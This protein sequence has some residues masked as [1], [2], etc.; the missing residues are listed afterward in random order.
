VQAKA[1]ANLPVLDSKGRTDHEMPKLH[2]SQDYAKYIN[3]RTAAWQN[4]AH[5]KK[6]IEVENEKRN[7]QLAKGAANK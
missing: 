6:A 1:V 5:H 4:S 3:Q 7:R 2:T